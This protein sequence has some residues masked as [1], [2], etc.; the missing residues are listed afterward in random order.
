M[1]RT[2][3]RGA[4]AALAAG[5]SL[6]LLA[7]CSGVPAD[8]G[9]AGMLGVTTSVAEARA[10]ARDALVPAVSDA[11]LKTPGTL[12]VGIVSTGSAPLVVM[13]SGG[14]PQGVDVDTAYALADELGLARVELVAV[15]SVE[16]GLS[17]TC[18]VVMGAHATGDDGYEVLGDYAQS[19]LGVFAAPGADAAGAPVSVTTLRSATVGVQR[20]SVSGAALEE[21]GVSVAQDEFANLNAAFEALEEGTLDYV[22]CDAYAGAYLANFYGGASFA[23]T[24]DEPVAVGVAVASDGG[25]LADAVGEAVEEIQ[26]NGVADIA[27]A[28]WMGEFPALSASDRLAGAA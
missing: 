2:H 25:A 4:L 20:G 21:L 19:A 14:T 23:G 27:R 17:G 26:S 11:D 1:K 10:A 28:R 5:V 18:D 16:A 3:A 12:T 24:L 9:L 6:A 22:V 15:Q 8:G 7:G 13:G